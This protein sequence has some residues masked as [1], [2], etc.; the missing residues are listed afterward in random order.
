MESGGA[1]SLALTILRP[2]SLLTGKNTGN[3]RVSVPR[4]R[5][6]ALQVAH[7]AGETDAASETGTGN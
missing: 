5:T 6:P 1:G 3:L 4:K 2:N 7:P